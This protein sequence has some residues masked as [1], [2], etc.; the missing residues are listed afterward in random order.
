MSTVATE[1]RITVFISKATPDDDEF[2]LWLAPRLEA[3][4]YTVYADIVRLD[5]GMRWR[6]ELTSTLQ[7]RAI[8]MLLCCQDSS[9]ARN[10][11]QEEIGIAE[12]LV[13]ELK[14]KEFIIP[15]RLKPYKKVFGIGELQYVDFS[16]SWADGLKDI[17]EKLKKDNVPRDIAAIRINPHWEQYRQRNAIAIRQEPEPLT[18]NWLRV[19]E[20]PDTIRYFTPRGAIDHAQF[21]KSVNKF[22]Y[23]GQVNERGFY[24]FASILDTNEELAHVASFDVG[25]EID[26]LS[27]VKDGLPDRGIKPREASNWVQSIFR[28]A[29]E[30]WA[31]EKG[32]LR[33]E[34]SKD[35]AFHVTQEQAK[36]GQRFRWGTQGESHSSM[37]RNAAKNHVWSFGVTGIPAFWP[38]Y[39]LKLKSRVLFSKMEDDKEGDVIKDKAVQHRLRRTVCKGWR[40]KQWHGRLR[41]MLELLAGESAFIDLAV[42][43]DERIRLDA[44][45]I[46]FTSP[47]TTE[48][49]DEAD[50]SAEE[51][52]DSTMTGPPSDEEEPE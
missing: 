18:S 39:H 37:L 10:G 1:P 19:V 25:H 4:G 38:Y 15:L 33:V 34:Y 23:H 6:Q 7:N 46:F 12:D 42:G 14:D 28:K 32:L 45:P 48:L 9:L 35:P 22:K 41:A 24:S 29:W 50:D 36:R 16:E 8:K 30:A 13:K 47:V 21:G 31:I 2:V 52:D 5:P 51:V 49:P 43:S 3:A 44:V 11:V 40:N 26:T 27:F 17:L 20:V